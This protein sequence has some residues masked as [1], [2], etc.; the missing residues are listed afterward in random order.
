MKNVKAIKR[1]DCTEEDEDVLVYSA[2]YNQK[3][4]PLE[5]VEF[6]SNGQQISK[7]TYEYDDKGRLKLEQIEGEDS[8]ATMKVIY[9]YGESE[10]ELTKTTYY[11]EDIGQKEQTFLSDNKQLVKRFHPDGA[12]SEETIETF[13]EDGQIDSLTYKNHDMAVSERHDFLYNEKN[14]LIEEKIFLDDEENRTIYWTYNEDGKVAL[15]EA[16]DVDGHLLN[17]HYYTYDNGQLVEEGIEEYES[18]NNQLRLKFN[19]NEHNQLVSRVEETYSGEL[20][21]ETSFELNEKGDVVMAGYI[22]TGLYAMLYGMA[23]GDY[24]KTIRNEIEYFE[25]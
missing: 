24:T 25:E 14:Q 4:Q 15:E 12:L 18:Y 10:K 19:Y 3:E 21:Q 16:K 8:G 20:I 6:A 23:E 7:N 9:E 13:R 17:R 2:I 1:Y 5:E 22:R 11:G